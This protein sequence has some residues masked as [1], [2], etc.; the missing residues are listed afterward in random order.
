VVRVSLAL[1]VLAGS[2]AW[3]ALRSADRDESG[4]VVDGGDLDVFQV[5]AGDCLGA[6]GDAEEGV[7]TVTAVPCD[8]PHESEVFALVDHP[9]DEDAEF[10]GE[11]AIGEFGDGECVEAFAT[12]VGTAYADSRY[13]IATFVPS[14]ESWADGDREVVCMAT[15]GTGGELSGSVRDA[16]R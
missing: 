13:G 14:P 1:V 11:D 7:S 4:A 12:Y 5:R 3:T 16:A 6:G 15:D 9:A 2:I 10:P 8:Q